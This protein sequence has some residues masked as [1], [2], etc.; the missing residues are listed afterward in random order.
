M[1][2]MNIDAKIMTNGVQKHI[3][4]KYTMTKWN[5]FHGWFDNSKFITITYW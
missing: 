1:L 3:K 2:F 4:K 5:L